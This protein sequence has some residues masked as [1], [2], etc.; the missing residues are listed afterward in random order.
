MSLSFTVFV[1]DSISM[2][3][4]VEKPGIQAVFFQS[5]R[6]RT[7]FLEVPAVVIRRD[8]VNDHHRRPLGFMPMQS[9][10]SPIWSVQ[11]HRF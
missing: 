1:V 9:N 8:S 11:L 5:D 7:V 10:A 3:S 2:P 6:Q 4:Q